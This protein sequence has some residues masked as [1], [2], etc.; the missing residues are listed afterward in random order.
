MSRSSAISLASSACSLSRWLLTDTYSPS[1]IETA[2]ATSPARPAVN[3][4]PRA[5]VAPATPTTMP[6][7]ETIP[8]LAPSTPARS[9]FSRPARP[10]ACGSW[11]CSG[12]TAEPDSSRSVTASLCSAGAE[13]RQQGEPCL[14]LRTGMV[15]HLAD[16]QRRRRGPPGG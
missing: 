12:G 15:T 7:T 3:T 8:S 13:F 6:A 5:G 14:I 11:P 1:A 4:G 16:R 9:Q 10:A 2:P